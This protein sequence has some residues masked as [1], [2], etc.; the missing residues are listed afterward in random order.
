M[1]RT[2]ASVGEVMGT[3]G[4]TRTDGGSGVERH[5]HRYGEAAQQVADL[6]LPG[7]RARGTAVLVHGGFWRSGFDRSLLERAAADLVG[8]GWAVWNVDYRGAGRDG[9]GWPGT[10]EDVAAALDAL[11]AP[12]QRHGLDP[13]RTI[14]VGHSAGG[15]LALWAAGRSRLPEEGAPGAPG[16]GPAPSTVLAPAAVVCLAGVAD[17]VLAD[18]DHLGDDATAGFLGGT[19]QEV[20]ERYALAD[21]TQQVPLEVPVLLVTGAQ[22]VTVP[23]S[24][25]RSYAAA[26]RAAGR[27]PEV[28]IVPDED[29]SAPQDPASGCWVRTREWLDEV[30][31]A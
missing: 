4:V 10:L 26:A 8:R 23:P 17:L 16:A 6:W 15:H 18:R 5:G 2:G 28:A 1:R 29:H 19:A 13:A 14:F 12:A 7:G 20:P 30:L 22:D 27:P 11:V 25:A 21:P 24:Q 3:G 9:G 31:P